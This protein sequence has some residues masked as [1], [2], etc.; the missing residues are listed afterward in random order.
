MT[1]KNAIKTVK[2]CLKND[3][4]KSKTNNDEKVNNDERI[5]RTKWIE[6]TSK[7]GNS[8]RILTVH[9]I[10][11]KIVASQIGAETLT[12]QARLDDPH[13]VKLCNDGKC[14]CTAPDAKPCGDDIYLINAC[15]T[16]RNT[17]ENQRATVRF[18]SSASR[19]LMSLP[20]ISNRANGTFTKRIFLFIFVF[21]LVD[22]N[23]NPWVLL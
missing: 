2:F 18:Q 15:T 10:L 20:G 12:D 9:D 11:W 8:I 16:V 19:H 3:I 21:F 5:K 13:I 4:E 14:P 22:Q 17:R 1:G 7:S 23:T 6:K